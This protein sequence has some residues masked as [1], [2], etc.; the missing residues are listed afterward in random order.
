[1]NKNT[2][3][4]LEYEKIKEILAGYAVSDYCKDMIRKLEPSCDKYRIEEWLAETT[5]AR[6]VADKTSSVPIHSLK[7][8]KNI[9]GKLGRVDILSPEDLSAIS[10]LLHECGKLKIFMADKANLAP[11]VSSYALSLYELKELEDEIDR[12]I[13]N[14]RVDDRASS[15]LAKI[16]KKMVFLEDKIKSKLEG[17]LKNSNYQTFLQDRVVSLRD[18]RFVIPI[19]NEHKRNV[20]GN[21]MGSSA[22]GSTVFIEPE[23][24]KRLQDDL[25]LLKID[26]EK[27]V[28]RILSSLTVL[29]E[30]NLMKIKINMEIMINYDFLFAKAKY[31]RAIEGNTVKLRGDKY[32]KIMDGKHPLIGK[33]AVPLNFEIGDKYRALVI[34]GPNTG[35]KTVALK[36]VGLLSM[37]VQS[38]L[39]VPVED[40]SEFAVFTDI[41]VDIGDGQSIEQSLSTFS[42]HI[43][44]IIGIME[45]SDS[46]TLVIMDELG[47]GTDPGEGMGIAISVLESVYE[48]G[49]TIIATTHYSEIKGFAESREGFE[50]GC[51]EFDI[52]TLKPLYKLSIGKAGESNAFLIAL[53]LGMDRKTIERAH[54]ITYKKKK[55]Y[56]SFEMKDFTPIQQESEEIKLHNE[57]VQEQKKRQEVREKIERKKIIPSFKIG[58]CVYI[59]T[60]NRTGIV[61]ELEN[62]KGEI[63]V[64]VMKKKL[65]INKKRLSLYVDSSELY[66][67]NYDF[68]I[69]FES[70]ENRKKDK[71]MSKHHIDGMTIE[72]D[73]I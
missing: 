47:A 50:N 43:K 73:N 3:E 55:E 52:D 45:C 19:K 26:E 10:G 35:G 5:E 48:K 4:L 28:Y 66:P 18:G 8:M 7:D 64:M 53:R 62:S 60:M 46:H 17:I 15:E 1:M 13:W 34:T 36:T 54:E 44:N 9:I 33:S 27:E 2:V 56:N 23:E 30:E 40:G 58:D 70:K 69:I 14:G 16:R 37:M 59:S 72:I 24:V 11:R 25:N 49:A 39:H 51:M 32:I 63:G 67:E 65:K 61:Y 22:S 41:L 57:R 31:S 42:S 68:D 20:E 6:A 21:I 38:G 12:C 71:I 29:V